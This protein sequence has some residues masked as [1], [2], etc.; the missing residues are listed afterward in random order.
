MSVF[1]R[2]QPG[3]AR[4]GHRARQEGPRARPSGA[5][6][7]R[8]RR[9]VSYIAT[10]CTRLLLCRYTTPCSVLRTMASLPPLEAF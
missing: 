8:R 6:P 4:L 7:Q 1:V 5:A 10:Y 2:L 3:G 9:A